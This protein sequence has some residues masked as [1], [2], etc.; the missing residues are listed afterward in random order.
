MKTIKINLEDKNTIEYIKNILWIIIA[1]LLLFVTV[2]QVNIEEEHREIK[3]RYEQIKQENTDLIKINKEQSEYIKILIKEANEQ[4]S[5]VNN[6]DTR[7][8]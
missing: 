5:I 3:N 2:G 7:E 1:V 8:E 6:R 4:S